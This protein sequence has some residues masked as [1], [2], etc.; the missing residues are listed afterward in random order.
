MK[1]AARHAEV[2]LLLWGEAKRHK[3]AKRIGSWNRAEREAAKQEDLAEFYKDVPEPMVTRQI[4]RTTDRRSFYRIRRPER[5][6]WE[7]ARQ[8]GRDV[9]DV[10]HMDRGLAR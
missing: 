5:W 7:L 6:R 10:S 2:A 4:M 1:A 3:Q 9:R 8:L